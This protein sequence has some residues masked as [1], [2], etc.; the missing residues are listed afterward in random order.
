MV[1]ERRQATDGFDDSPLFTNE[2]LKAFM[3]NNRVYGAEITLADVL[4]ICGTTAAP[5][6]D[7]CDVLAA[8][9]QK[10]ELDSRGAQVWKEFWAVIRRE[11]GNSFQNIVESDRFWRIDFDPAD[12]LNT[13]AGIDTD[14][15]INPKP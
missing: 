5:I 2:N 15:P 10:V 3:Y 8:W 14:N 9:D 11:L 1:E 12:P 6:Q 4:T 13:P 7:A